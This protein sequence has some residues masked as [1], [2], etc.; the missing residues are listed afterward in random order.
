MKEVVKKEIIKLLNTSIIY[1]IEDSPW[2]SLIHCVPKKGGV[3][4]VTNEKNKLVPTSTITGWRVCIDYQKLNE[5]TRKDHF[6]LPFMD[7]MLEKLADDQEKTTFTC[8]YGTNA[9]NSMPFGL[10]NAPA[11]FQR[12]MIAIFKTCLKPP[13]KFSWMISYIWRFF[14][15]CLLN[16]EQMLTRCKQ[17]HLV[18]NWEK[19]YFMMMEGIVL[20][21]KVSSAELEADKA[22]INIKFKK[23]ADY[24]VADHLS[25]L[26]NLNREEL[27]DEDIDEN[28]LDETLMNISSND[29]EEIP[30]FTLV[31]KILRKGLMYAQ[32]CKL[33]SELKHYSG[34][35]RI[36]SKCALMG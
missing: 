32:R 12:C 34:M 35:N 24:V 9:Y 6:P 2:L 20:G 11:T 7:Q 17:A 31:G 21:H 18:L 16:L 25:R 27:R 19:C 15:S 8:P 26:E 13:W 14:D 1:P 23:G 10:C 28:F 29:E 3:T 36:S 33:F 22:K 5:A 4:V 30:W